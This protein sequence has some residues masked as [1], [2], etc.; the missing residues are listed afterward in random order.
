VE[1]ML[2]NIKAQPQ[3]IEWRAA[4]LKDRASKARG[5][6]RQFH[7]DKWATFNPTCDIDHKGAAVLLSRRNE[8]RVCRL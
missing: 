4:P 1:D 7:P 8:R 3:W 6:A 5:I 2:V